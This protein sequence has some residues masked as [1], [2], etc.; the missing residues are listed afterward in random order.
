M[1]KN[2]LEPYFLPHVKINFRWITGLNVKARK[3]VEENTGAFLSGLSVGRF[4]KT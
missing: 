4:L 1:G 2:H 3:L